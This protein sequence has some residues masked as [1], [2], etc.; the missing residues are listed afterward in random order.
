[1]E[2][3]IWLRNNNTNFETNSLNDNIYYM[4][5]NIQYNGGG[6]E[7]RPC[8]LLMCGLSQPN[9]THIDNSLNDINYLTELYNFLTNVTKDRIHFI[10]YNNK[11]LKKG[12]VF[13]EFNIFWEQLQIIIKQIENNIKTFL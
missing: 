9:T 7:D 4:L 2:E 12:K 11:K 13:L 3:Y 8:R 6:G 10:Y 5:E 1:M